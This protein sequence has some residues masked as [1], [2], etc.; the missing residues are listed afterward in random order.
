MP[1]ATSGP[2]FTAMELPE[3]KEIHLLKERID[4]ENNLLMQRT[5]WVVMSQAFMLTG[6]AIVL[7]SVGDGLPSGQA[8]DLKALTLLLP[9]TAIVS[10]TLLYVTIIAA[11]RSMASLRDLLTRCHPDEHPIILGDRLAFLGGTVAPLL[12]P[13]TF[14]FTWIA[15][16]LMR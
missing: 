3:T 16:A 5:T 2:M 6:Y 11:V 9:W 4:H 14:L 12:A 8:R 1:P 7:G 10:L 15:L 13:A